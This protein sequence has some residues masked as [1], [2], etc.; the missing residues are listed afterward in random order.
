M[1][2]PVRAF[3]SVGVPP[4]FVQRAKGSHVWDIDGNKYIDYIGSWGPMLLGH[5]PDFLQEGALEAIGR[6]ISYG[7]PTTLEV[8]MAELITSAYPAGRDGPAW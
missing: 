6:G 8:E 2:S 4:V 3:Q 5:S 7:L 1:N